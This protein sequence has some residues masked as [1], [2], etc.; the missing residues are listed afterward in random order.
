MVNYQ[1]GKIYKIVCNTSGLVYIGSTCQKSLSQRLSEHV[2]NYKQYLIQKKNYISSFELIK[3]GNYDII[4]IENSPCNT[5]DELYM[6][7]RF[8]CVNMVN[9]IRLKE[10]N[11]KYNK[12]Y[13]QENQERE[14]LR[15][16]KY[17]EENKEKVK[18][19]HHNY[20]EK[21]KEKCNLISKRYREENRE[22][23]QLL[24]KKY[25][26]ENKEKEKLRHKKYYDENKDKT[27]LYTQNYREAKREAINFKQREK[28]R[29]QSLY[30][31]Q[32]KYYNL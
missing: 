10:D 8:Q 28:R 24:Y 5:K 13:Y 2:S 30:L 31:E 4:L 22:K 1:Q 9:P 27:K 19:Y 17:L 26:N 29:L 14:K 32:L 16:K 15:R 7:E 18:I 20:H 21:N 25:C 12:K 23:I 3:H 11:K 6:R